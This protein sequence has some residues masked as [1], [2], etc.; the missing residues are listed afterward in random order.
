MDPNPPSGECRRPA[1][2]AAAPP[3]PALFSR[4]ALGCLAAAGVAFDALLGVMLADLW[5]PR[6]ALLLAGT[7]PVTLCLVLAFLDSRRF[8][9]TLRVLT[10]AVFLALSAHVLNTAL[11][12]GVSRHLALQAAAGFCLVGLPALAY[13]LWGHPGGPLREDDPGTFTPGNLASQVLLAL[14][15]VA[16]MVLLGMLAAGSLLALRHGAGGG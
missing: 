12:G 13:T 5:D 1:P 14:F 9:W 7:L 16:G 11:K 2:K 15:A 8:E 4:P 3:P 6:P 10:G